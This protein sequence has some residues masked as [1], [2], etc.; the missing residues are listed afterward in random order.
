MQTSCAVCRAPMHAAL[1]SAARTSK[2][3]PSRLPHLDPSR[4]Q[5]DHHTAPLPLLSFCRTPPGSSCRWWPRCA[6]THA[7]WSRTRMTTPSRPL[8]WWGQIRGA[9]WAAGSGAPPDRRP[10]C[11]EQAGMVRWVVSPQAACPA[12]RHAYL[13]TCPHQPTLPR[14]PRPCLADQGGGGPRLQP[15]G[16]GLHRRCLR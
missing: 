6:T 10:S 14:S 11:M 2:L 3:G 15:A 16:L 7:L 9:G 12:G 13:P 4:H 1:V 8:T 5:H